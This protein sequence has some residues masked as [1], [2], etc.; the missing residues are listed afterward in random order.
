MWMANYLYKFLQVTPGCMLLGPGSACSAGFKCEDSCD[1]NARF[2]CIGIL[3]HLFLPTNAIFTFQQVKE[4][5]LA[6]D[7]RSSI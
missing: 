5:S 3:F 1:V 4:L 7:Y 2:K 6:T